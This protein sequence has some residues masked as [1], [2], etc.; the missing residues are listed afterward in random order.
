MVTI[1]YYPDP[2]TGEVEIEEVPR[3]IDFLRRFKTKEA[4]LDL[5]FFIGN[6]GGDEIDQSNTDF[7]FITDKTIAVTR[8]SCLPKTGLEPWMFYAI[9]FVASTAVSYYLASHVSTPT[10]RSDSTST[11]ST[12]SLSSPTNS[13]RV[14]KRI[15][16]AFGFIRKHTPDLGQV[17]YRIGIDNQE[18]EILFLILGRGKYQTW[19]NKW[20]DG[21]TPMQKIPNTAVNKYEPG[22]WPGNGSP[23]QQIGDVIDQ[24]LGIYKVLNDLSS[25]ELLPPNELDTSLGARWSITSDGTTA[26]LT[27]TYLPDGF[28]IKDSFTVLS[29]LTLKDF[30]YYGS[31]STKKFYDNGGSPYTFNTLLTGVDLGDAGA[32]EYEI[33][34]LTETTIVINIPKDVSTKIAAAWSAMSGGYIVPETVFTL[35]NS[36]LGETYITIDSRADD[37]TYY[38]SYSMG[39]PSNPYRLTKTGRTPLAAMPYYD[40]IGPVDVSGYDEVLLNFVSPNGFYKYVENKA[41]TVSADVQVQFVE[42]DSDGVETGNITPYTFTYSSNLKNKRKSVF[43]TKRYVVPYDYCLVYCKRITN[44]DHNENVSN[45]DNIEWRDIYGFNENPVD[46]DLGDITTAHVLIPSNSQSR[47]TKDRKQNMDLMRLITRYNGNGSF[48]DT[49]AY[50]TDNFA[51]IL[52]H[53]SLDNRIGRQTIGSIN[54]DGWLEISDEIESYFGSTEMTRFGYVFDDYSTTYQDH[55]LTVSNVVNC[56]PFSQNAVYDLAFEKK[57]TESVMQL[58]C[59]NKRSGTEVREINFEKQYDGVELSYRS[60]E[61]GE[62]YTIYLPEDQSAANPEVINFSGCITYE[63]A[64]KVAWRKYQKQ[65]HSR[66]TITIDVDEFGRCIIPGKRLDSPDGTR[67]VRRKDV[68]DGY[69]VFDGEVVEVNGLQVELSEPLV[70]TEGEDH[71]ITFTAESGDSMTPILCTQVDDFTVLLSQLPEEAIYDGYE[72]DR[73]KFVFC[74]EQLQQSIAMI[75]Q[76]IDFTLE[77]DGSETN[78]ITGINYS[79]EY[80]VHDLDSV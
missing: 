35:S 16:D 23:S 12:N 52:I 18:C 56:Y 76:T 10:T 58:T 39:S 54:A 34:D 71:Y 45:I 24:K 75:P 31:N 40:T 60:G 7:L 65:I 80:Y 15:T 46:M 21:D 77:D 32:Q 47:L 28:V 61:D 55:F 17:P 43:Q 27:A 41:N 53:L 63:Q 57:Q 11:S 26:T 2:I 44:R 78:T 42:T 38:D 79:D 9:I 22:T 74:S 13:A 37:R 5:R 72:K 29:N 49:E 1:K 36:G 20:Y 33:A 66:E 62:T 8:G 4:L 67:F 25:A 64:Y 6:I 50:A 3:V 30:F 51:Q 69:R 14:G 68:E 59:R 48:G 70:F 19:M 73:T